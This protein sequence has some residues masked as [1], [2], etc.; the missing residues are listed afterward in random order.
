MPRRTV[1]IAVAA[2]AAGVAAAAC[3][4]SPPPELRIG[5]LAT[6][7]GLYAEASGVPT[8]DGAHLAVSRASDLVLDGRRY[9]V[10]I[11]ERDFPDRPDAAA[12][13]ARALINRDSVHVLIGP[14]FSRHAAA[15]AVVAEAAH[16]PMITPMASNAAV[17]DGKR[18]AFRLAFLDDAQG[19]VLAQFARDRL[20]ARTAAM[21]FDVGN[22]YSREVATRFRR[23]FEAGG[24]RVT[25][26]EPYT[27]DRL[28]A[29]E[30]V[31]RRMLATNPDV[32]L[33]PNFP[34][35]VRVQLQLVARLGLRGTLL[36]SDS[37]DA[38][39]LRPLLGTR[40]AYLTS[41]WRPDLPRPETAAFIAAYREAYGAEPRA[42]AAMTY[43]AVGIVLDAARRAGRIDPDALRDAIAAT[44]GYPG[45]GATYSFNGGADPARAVAVSIVTVDSMATAWLAE[46]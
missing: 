45:A 20:R 26:A 8:R 14:Q 12:S 15:V 19:S 28:S 16:I 40:A 34:D 9:T 31:L 32:L 30:P 10:R 2:L 37:W 44:T 35:A 42:G 43:D 21:L 3:R 22:L 27:A 39:A 13:A 25:A 6:F 24:G 38:P 29:L 23:A 5:L 46:P 7:T 33:L 1:L 41:Q 18:W 4:P 17:T 36:G 11:I